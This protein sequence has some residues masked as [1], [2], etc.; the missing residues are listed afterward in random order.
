VI[1]GLAMGLRALCLL[2]VAAGCGQSL[3][4]AHGRR[5]GGG[6]GDDAGDDGGGGD[7]SVP[8]TCPPASC[9]ADA[10]AD[11]TKAQGGANGHWFYREDKRNRSWMTMS[12]DATGLVG[13]EA[14]NRIDPCT[15]SADGCR[16]LSSALLVSSSALTADPAIEFLSFVP[17]VVQLALRVRVD[18]GTQRVRLYRNSR[19]DVLFTAIGAPGETVMSTIT[20]DALALDKFLVAIEPTDGTAGLAAVQFFVIDAGKSFPQT[21]L[22]AIPFTASGLGPNTVRDLC[23]STDFLYRN[24]NVSSTPGFRDDAFGK[25]STAGYFEPG[26]NYLGAKPLSRNG[27]VTVQ[28]WA[29]QDTPVPTVGTAWLFSDFDENTG[30]GLGIQLRFPAPLRIEAS[31]LTA[32]GPPNYTFK[33]VNFG[34]PNTWYFVRV[35]HA[36]GMVTICLDGKQVLNTSLVGPMASGY[37]PSLARNAPWETVSNLLGGLD[38][39]RVFSGVLPCN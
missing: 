9:I 36:G 17:K 10:A 31:A 39:V 16:A 18:R 25:S 6:G 23:G 19:E 20:L 8:E 7:G 27:D 35:I 28:F 32:V 38:D 33:G 3:F 26:F 30:G 2:L 4:D 11:F 29:I 1:L 5:D 13:A 37:P 12:P 14:G 34:N 24:D 21:C 15:S 22:L